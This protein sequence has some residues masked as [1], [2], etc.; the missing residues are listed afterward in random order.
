MSRSKGEY[1]SKLSAEE[2]VNIVLIQETHTATPEELERRGVISGFNMIVA[3][4]SRAHGIAT[5]AKE[6]MDC[7][8]VLESVSRDNIYSS[9]TRIGALSVTNVCKAPT[10]KWPQSVLPL[11]PHPSIYA[12]DF[13]SHHSEW[14]YRDDDENGESLVSWA[15]T[16]ELLLVHDSK[17]RRTF[18]SKA[19][20]TESNPDLCFVSADIEGFPL[21]VSR[22]VLPA[23]LNSHHRPVILDVGMNVPIITYVQRPRWNFLKANW[24][25]YS[26]FLDAAIRFI[27]PSP[28]N[29]DRFNNLVISTAKKCVPRGYRK[30]YI[31]CWNDDSDRLYAEF[32]DNEDPETAKEL[33]KSLDEARKQRWIE[34]VENINMTKSSRK[35]WSIIRKLG[36]ASKLC[37]KKPKINADRIARR[38]VRS[39]K[40]PPK[41]Y[42][43]KKVT[44]TYRMIRKGTPATNS[45]NKAL[46][47]FPQKM[48]PLP[49]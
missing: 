27:P 30:E 3:E 11:Q 38:V 15:S 47:L 45:S 8:N 41:K 40:A 36:G 28:Q 42:F 2:D 17:D 33:L 43:T 1:I 20:R 4:Y 7:V 44:Q 26:S 39:S 6:G 19:H 21:Q 31:P 12:G 46:K 18:Y 34:T 14:D 25:Q 13:N 22:K 24:N 5:Y 29:Y 35:G 9:T 37:K 16:A 49:C 23:S 32:Q 10:T 48:P